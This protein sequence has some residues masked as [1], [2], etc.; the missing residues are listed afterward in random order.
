LRVNR[1]RRI[2]GSVDL[3][4][5]L[6]N[7]FPQAARWDYGIGY[8]SEEEKVFWIEVHPASSLH[9]N[10]VI[11]KLQWLKQWLL[12]QATNL[13]NLP[14]QFIWIA[15]GN[16]SL[17]PGSPQRKRLALNGLLFAGETFSIKN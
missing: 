7:A 17:Q 14:R 10:E 11:S 9:V 8:S 16:V 12:T 3:D 4:T 6:R 5:A 13:D 15:S 2:T 1:T